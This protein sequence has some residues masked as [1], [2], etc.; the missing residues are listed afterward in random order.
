L[1]A[2]DKGDLVIILLKTHLY[3][4]QRVRVLGGAALEARIAD[5]LAMLR[6]LGHDLPRPPREYL[7]QWV[8][9]GYLIRRYPPGADEEEYE[10]SAA[11]LDAIRFVGNLVNP[12]P[13]MT[14]SRL[15]LV[16]AAVSRLAEDTDPDTGR[17]AQRLREDLER[18]KAELSEV[19]SGRL[20]VIDENAAKER[21]KEIVALAEGLIEDF[22]RV[23]DQFERLAR[24]FREK[25]HVSRA[26]RG[27][28]LEGF[29]KGYL[30]LE[31][32]DAGRTFAAFYK[33]LNDEGQQSLL[34]SSLKRIR[35]EPFFEGLEPRER[36]LLTD[37]VQDLVAQATSIA[38]VTLAMDENLRRFV[39]GPEYQRNQAL[40]KALYRA[41]SLAMELKDRLNPVTRLESSLNLSARRLLSIS[42]LV[43]IPRGPKV[44]PGPFRKAQVEAGNLAEFREA[45]SAAE[46]DFRTLKDNVLATLKVLENPSILDVLERFPAAQGLAS[47]VGLVHL[48][49]RHGDREDGARETVG[50]PDPGGLERTARIDRWFFSRGKAREL[51]GVDV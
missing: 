44:P 27:E 32:T 3:D 2:A 46:I 49:H 28:V 29:F 30:S 11:A 31:S 1:L 19:E 21:A 43:W 14:E 50:W 15:A 38:K 34:T 33:L 20:G 5:G 51:E 37:L 16:I 45:V 18:R 17:R 10:L 35:G 7:N 13:T 26:P 12:L 6:R 8:T 40:I 22:R 4:D 41:K 23:M 9:D 39:E 47:V 36:L 24:G 42:Q 48:A 25:V